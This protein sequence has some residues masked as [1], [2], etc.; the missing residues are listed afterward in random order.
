M[1]KRY[2]SGSW[3]SKSYEFIKFARLLAGRVGGILDLSGL[4]DVGVDGKQ[5]KTGYQF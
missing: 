2:C 5:L 3:D 4:G 1:L